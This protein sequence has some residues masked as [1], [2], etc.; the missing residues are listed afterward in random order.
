M[1]LG[2]AALLER[3][4]KVVREKRRSRVAI[5]YT[6]YSCFLYH[7]CQFAVQIV[8]RVTRH[9]RNTKSSRLQIFDGPCAVDY[10]YSAFHITYPQT[11]QG[12][13][14]W[15]YIISYFLQ[16]IYL[17]KMMLHIMDGH[18]TQ[19]DKKTERKPINKWLNKGNCVQLYK[20]K[21]ELQSVQRPFFFG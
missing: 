5:E 8:I 21:F 3:D 20:T 19:Q 2:G 16:S 14:L 13:L 4:L 9:R 11:L 10:I 15:F 12:S 18:C 1:W 7:C 6:V 17:H